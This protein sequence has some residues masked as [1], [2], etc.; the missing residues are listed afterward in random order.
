VAR[1]TKKRA[2]QLKHDKFRDTAMGFFDRLGDRLEGQGRNILYAIAGLVGVFVIYFTYSWWSEAKADKARFALGKAIETSEARIVSGTPDPNE[3]RPTFPSERERAQKAVEEFQKVQQ[4][5]GSPYSE[6]ARF[7]A[8]TNLLDV[9]RARG[10]SELEE[11]S[12]SSNKEVAARAKF[13]LGQAKEADGQLDQ[14]ATIYQELLNASEKPIA[15]NTLKLRVASVLEKQDKKDAAVDILFRMV[16]DARKLQQGKE[17]K[18]SPESGVVRTASEKLQ[19]LSPQRYAQLPPEP[20]SARG[21]FPS[22]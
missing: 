18:P 6:L 4:E 22:M 13:A 21:G 2:K 17:N 8:A 9:D 10:M 14:A 11:L 20:V 5:F 1:T 19:K 16:E 12:R 3:T 15:E 7:F